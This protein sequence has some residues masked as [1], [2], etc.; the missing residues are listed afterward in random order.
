MMPVSTS[1]VPAVASAGATGGVD[2]DAAVGVGD[3]G[4]GPLEQHDR[5]AAVGELARG[6]D[7]VVADRVARE[8]FVLAR[9]AG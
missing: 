2:R 7:P 9:R 6:R 3:D 8:P 1:P 5:P 4:A